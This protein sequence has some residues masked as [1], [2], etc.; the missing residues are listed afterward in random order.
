LLIPTVML[1]YERDL[2][3]DNVS[4]QDIER[5]LGIRVSIVEANADDFVNKV[6][7]E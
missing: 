6:L 3:L 4:V 2:F 5:E 1:R 7:G